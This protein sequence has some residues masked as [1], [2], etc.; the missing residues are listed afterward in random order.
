[1]AQIGVFLATGFEEC[2]ALLV[3]DIC[4]RSG[5]DLKTV[6][7]TGEKQVISSCGFIAAGC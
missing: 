2:E 1:M 5:I 3:V 4:R 7:V 6:S